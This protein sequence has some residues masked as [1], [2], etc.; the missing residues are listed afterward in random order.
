MKKLLVLALVLVFILPATATVWGPGPRDGGS[1]GG[2]G[3]ESDD[4][5]DSR[6][7][8]PA[9]DI[10]AGVVYYVPE[11]LSVK[12]SADFLAVLY[13]EFFHRAPDKS[14]YENNLNRLTSGTSRAKLVVSFAESDE[15]TKL[16]GKSTD[17][18]FLVT[19]YNTLLHRPGDRDGMNSYYVHMQRDGWSRVKVA[20]NILNSDEYA[21]KHV[22]AP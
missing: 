10:P 9:T 6:Y 8:L 11:N 14:G 15:N 16:R 22:D 17:V 20:Q 1:G 4:D 21:S 5:S 12:R 7:S 19:L 2:G 3:S 18:N 13:M